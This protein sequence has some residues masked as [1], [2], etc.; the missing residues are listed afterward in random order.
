V[1]GVV[2]IV[3][4]RDFSRDLE[5]ESEIIEHGG[6]QIWEILRAWKRVLRRIHAH[7]LENLRVFAQA[8]PLE[9]RRGDLTAS[10]ALR[11]RVELPEP[12]FVSPTRRADEHALRG[13]CRHLLLDLVTVNGN[14][15]SCRWYKMKST[16]CE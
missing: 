12:S 13:N 10:L 4:D 16:R 9:A 6:G 14:A 1:A 11:W 2:G 5:A 15:Q 3:L 8:I 7:R